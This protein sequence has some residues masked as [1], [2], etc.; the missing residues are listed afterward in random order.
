MVPVDRTNVL[1]AV[2]GLWSLV[3]LSHQHHMLFVILCFLWYEDVYVRLATLSKCMETGSN[4]KVHIFRIR[5]RG[6]TLTSTAL[7][8]HKVIAWG[9]T[10]TRKRKHKLDVVPNLVPMDRKCLK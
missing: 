8:G 7:L 4:T 6:C 2:R 5:I 10:K 1:Y 3:A 9:K